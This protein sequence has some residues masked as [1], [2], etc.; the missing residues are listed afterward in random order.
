[1]MYRF[2][3]SPRWVA[4]SLVVAAIATIFV[5]LG[6]WQLR[7]LEDRRFENLVGE[8]RFQDV[9]VDLEILL[10]GANPGDLEYRR[11]TVRGRYDREG[12]VLVRSQVERG[13]AGFHVVTPLLPSA[14]DPAV[15]V[16]RGW[17][18]L[19]MDS[20]PV[21]AAPPGGEVE[22]GGWLRPGQSRPGMGPVDQPSSKVVSRVDID[23]IARQ[24]GYDVAPV[25]M[26]VLDGGE[27]E[28]PIPAPPPVFDDEGPHLAYAVQW[29]AFALIGLVGY[30]F[31]L[32]R[33]ALSTP[34]G[35]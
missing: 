20:P 13:V 24:L 4:T 35:R 12:E 14:G 27:G 8:A 29:F 26:V 22:V 18:P 5:G 11:A 19:E 25:F 23:L 2:L 21:A 17:V 28:L 34:S 16:N 30:G 32:R 9:A 15:L 3:L 33:R 1:M 6:L 31:L 10:D 7:R